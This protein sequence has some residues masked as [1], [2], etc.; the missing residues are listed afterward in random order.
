MNEK[1]VDSVKLCSDI[2]KITTQLYQRYSF[3]EITKEEFQTLMK[4]TVKN[5]MYSKQARRSKNPALFF[6]RC[7]EHELYLK[8]GNLIQTK[9]EAVFIM[10]QFLNTEWMKNKVNRIM[11][12]NAFGQFIENIHYEFDEPFCIYFLEQS[13]TI[14]DVLKFVLKRLKQDGT[15]PGLWEN[16]N[17]LL[18]VQ[19][20]SKLHHIPFK[21]QVKKQNPTFT[22]SNLETTNITTMYLNEL[23][24]TPLLTKSEERELGFQILKGD[25]LAVKELIERNLRLVVSIATKFS[26]SN[27]SFLDLIQEGNL[28]LVKAAERFDVT[29]DGAFSTYA[30]S[31]ITRYILRIVSKNKVDF[32]TPRYIIEQL[33]KYQ[34]VDDKWKKNSNIPPTSEYL[35][36]QLKLPEKQIKILVE[37][38]SRSVVS[39]NQTVSGD[40]SEELGNVIS[41]PGEPLEEIVCQSCLQDDINRLCVNCLSSQEKNVVR[42]FGFNDVA[43]GKKLGL[44]RMRVGQL[45]TS[46][47]TKLRLSSLTDKLIDY[48]DDPDYGL[49]TLQT[50]RE[51]QIKQPIIMSEVKV[52]LKK[53]GNLMALSQ[54]N[55]TE[56]LASTIE[57]LLLNFQILMQD[58]GLSSSQIHKIQLHYF[59]AE[60]PMP[61]E[62]MANLCGCKKPTIGSSMYKISLSLSQPANYQK[63]RQYIRDYNEEIMK[64]QDY[65][66]C[67]NRKKGNSN[68]QY[69]DPF[70]HTDD[71]L[72]TEKVFFKK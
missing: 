42:L 55:H 58:C 57:I 54:M 51:N 25:Q 7:L 68:S 15:I 46:A 20:Y 36:E 12:L 6:E 61:Y 23:R 8:I 34:Q 62:Q 31:Y 21:M 45:K 59:A 56:E 2:F 10:E 67:M 5:Y 17:I 71:V 63:I 27:L 60:K 39:L 38:L 1:R 48:V 26:K 37:L 41:D 9:K 70:S 29:I 28:A 40:R 3:L 53:F 43:I 14:N 11:R 66:N 49:Q 65:T 64:L 52:W 16:P 32:Y 19:T 47:I 4:E 18:L 50:F 33:V 69:A 35:T 72:E 13:E 30:T 24:R 44:T 22:E